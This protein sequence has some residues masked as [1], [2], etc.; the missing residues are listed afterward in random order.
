MFPWGTLLVGVAGAG[1]LATLGARLSRAA[2]GVPAPA[3]PRPRLGSRDVALVLALLGVA[4]LLRLW[5]LESRV[6]DNDEPASLG[7]FDLDSWARDDDARL[8][9]PLAGLLLSA[10]F[11]ARALIGDARGVSTLAGVLTVAWVYLALF[12]RGR[13]RALAGGA[14]C[15]IAPAML[16]AS[17]LARGYALAAACLLAAHLALSRALRLGT[18]RSWLLYLVAGIGCL[19]TEYVT[20][21]PL[22]A[23]ALMAFADRRTTRAERIRVTTTVG[24]VLAVG[25]LFVPFAWS[26][27]LRGVGG[28]PRSPEGFLPSLME[29]LD[30]VGAGFGV[31]AGALILIYVAVITLRGSTPP[32]Q[33]RAGAAVLA[34]LLLL[35]V[36]GLIT[37]MRPRYL[38]PAFPL[39]I[40]AT[41]G[42]TARRDLTAGIAAALVVAQ[43]LL[44][45]CYLSQGCAASELS[46]GRVLAATLEAARSHSRLPLVV[47][48]SWAIAEPSYRLLHAFPG[49]DS[50]RDCPARLCVSGRTF[51]GKPRELYGLNEDELATRLGP[52]R[53]S[54]KLLLL[55]RGNERRVVG[56]A[57]VA[58]DPDAALLLCD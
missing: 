45:P 28:P 22:C 21:G 37:A 7:L 49:P 27:T 17:Q 41:L 29:G 44:L 5:H 55:H 16:H 46:R 9:P 38:L 53:A 3:A 56:C 23:E 43:G 25:A 48:P 42:A 4:L 15:A 6:L 33:R 50:R 35:G 19:F 2:K 12:P 32:A 39:L 11:A 18:T 51:D 1:A 54:G 8:H 10:A 57:P 14:L 34:A 31:G 52:L 20:L 26:T 36:G 13:I 24:G 47:V 58:E 40:V 30:L